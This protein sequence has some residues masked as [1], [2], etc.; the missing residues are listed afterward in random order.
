[1]NTLELDLLAVSA[2]ATAVPIT[3]L[4]F[5]SSV[6]LLYPVTS[7]ATR[8]FPTLIAS[9]FPLADRPSAP[10]SNFFFPVTLFSSLNPLHLP[11]GPQ[12]TIYTAAYFF[13][14]HLILFFSLLTTPLFS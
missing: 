5:V 11:F 7:F 13:P 10:P 6:K 3:S 14:V 9:I 4:V 2:R 1:M 8:I 12:W